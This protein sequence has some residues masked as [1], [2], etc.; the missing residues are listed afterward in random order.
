RLRA[1][2]QIRTELSV[3]SASSVGRRASFGLS[4][5][6]LTGGLAAAAVAVVA[7]LVT[8]SGLRLEPPSA[9]NPTAAAVAVPESAAAAEDVQVTT[10][11]S[12]GGTMLRWQASGTTFLVL[13][14]NQPSTFAGAEV[15]VVCGSSWTDREPAHG[16]AYYRVV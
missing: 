5:R 4:W 15:T 6:W 14:S 12:S 8:S 2:A 3:S 7:A 11:A 16:V 10:V 9:P 1:L 13:K